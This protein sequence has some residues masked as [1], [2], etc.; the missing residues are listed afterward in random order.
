MIKVAKLNRGFHVIN[1]MPHKLI[2]AIKIMPNFIWTEYASKHEDKLYYIVDNHKL[3]FICKDY[4]MKIVFYYQNEN[5]CKEAYNNLNQLN[6]NELRFLIKVWG[7]RVF[8]MDMHRT[9]TIEDLRKLM[10]NKELKK[11]GIIY[12]IDNSITIL[13]S[14]IALEMKKIES[15]KLKEAINLMLN[16]IVKRINKYKHFTHW[17]DKL[18]FIKEMDNTLDEYTYEIIENYLGLL[19]DTLLDKQLKEKVKEV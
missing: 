9:L 3:K 15:D 18:N 19:Y 11:H 10:E 2:N 6:E 8:E 17:E 5:Y 7:N 1:Q 14:N 13:C 12:Y 16:T 4:T